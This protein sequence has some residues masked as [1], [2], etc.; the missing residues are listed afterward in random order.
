MRNTSKI[1]I[2]SLILINIFITKLLYDKSVKYNKL[3]ELAAFSCINH[4]FFVKNIK[5]SNVDFARKNSEKVLAT[6]RTIKREQ[7]L[8]GKYWKDFDYY[9][10]G[11]IK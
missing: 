11:L 2:I 4:Y 1:T 10:E 8:S 5:E 6:I 3:E 9:V 7:G